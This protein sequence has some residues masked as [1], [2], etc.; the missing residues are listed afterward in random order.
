MAVYLTF[1]SLTA[2]HMHH[3]TLCNNCH[4]FTA[5]TVFLEVHTESLS[6]S[7]KVDISFVMSIPL[8]MYISLAVI[9]VNLQNFFIVDSYAKRRHCCISM[10]TVIAQTCQNVML[11]VI[12]IITC[13]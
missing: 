1:I 3:N 7:Q 8:P 13:V 11:Q 12:C 9:G 10:A 4:V 6:V 5:I 2:T